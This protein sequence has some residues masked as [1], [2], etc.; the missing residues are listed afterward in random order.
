MWFRQARRHSTWEQCDTDLFSGCV[1]SGCLADTSP[2]ARLVNSLGQ[3]AASAVTNLCSGEPRPLGRVTAS[4]LFLTLHL[5]KMP[6]LDSDLE[7][8]T[9]MA[10]ILIG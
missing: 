2:I 3:D 1:A 7:G 10:G 6:I 5:Q 9:H 4:Y 8:N